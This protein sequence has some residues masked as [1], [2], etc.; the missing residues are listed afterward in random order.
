MKN[1]VLFYVQKTL[2]FVTWKTVFSFSFI[3]DK[4]SQYFF[5]VFLYNLLFYYKLFLFLLN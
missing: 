3:E 2:F 4:V 1:Y 5:N